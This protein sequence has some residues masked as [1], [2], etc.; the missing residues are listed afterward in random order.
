MDIW[1]KEQQVRQPRD[2]TACLK[3]S[4][5]ATMVVAQRGTGRRQKIRRGEQIIQGLLGH[6]KRFLWLLCQEKWKG[7][8]KIREQE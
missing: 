6:C 3:N 8:V 7:T 5:M 4:K 2:S 1:G